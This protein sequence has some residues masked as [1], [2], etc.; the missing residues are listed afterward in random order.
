MQN[1]LRL[2]QIDIQIA[3]LDQQIKS[4]ESSKST[5]IILMVASLFILWPL[6]IAGAIMYGSANNKIKD[7]NSQKQMLLMERNWYACPPPSN[8]FQTNW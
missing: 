6:L 3:A 5:A 1:T 2:Q 8:G 4:A 7:L